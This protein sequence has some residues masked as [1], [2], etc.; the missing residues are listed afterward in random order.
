MDFTQSCLQRTDRSFQW[1]EAQKKML[2]DVKAVVTA[3]NC[4]P[5]AGKTTMIIAFM[6]QVHLNLVL[7]WWQ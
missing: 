2:S 4:A 6:L 7:Q 3:I 5:G 1:S